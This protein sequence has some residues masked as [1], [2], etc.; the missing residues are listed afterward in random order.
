MR[1]KKIFWIYPGKLETSLD[2][3]TWL[4]TSKYLKEYGWNVEIASADLNKGWISEQKIKI[5]SFSR[6]NLY[7]FSN[8]LFHFL[9]AIRI[10]LSLNKIDVILFNQDSVPIMGLLYL[11][12][13]K[14]K[15][16]PYFILDNRSLPMA[17]T[18]AK[19]KIRTRFITWANIAAKK[20]FDGQTAITNRMAEA[21]KI[22]KETLLA[23]WPSG[24]N[25]EDFKYSSINRKARN[26]GSMLRLIYIGSIYRERN[27][28]EMCQAVDELATEGYPVSILL[29]GDGPDRQEL[30]SKYTFSHSISIL[31]SVPGQLVPYILANADVG[32]LPFPDEERFRVSS[33]IKLFE[34]LAAGMPILATKIACHTDVIRQN[35]VFWAENASVSSLSAAILNA[36]GNDGKFKEMQLLALE[37]SKNHTWEIAAKML[38]DGL[39]NSLFY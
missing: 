29:V 8:I 36:L 35:C 24:V 5:T 9:V 27:L 28:F 23:V 10:V 12:I 21:L 33:P 37:E 34:Y 31:P 20:L 14:L 18:T 19:E 7:L 16:R 30:Q 2:R 32:V 39:N 4:E 11:F 13:K 38:S 15:R 1:Y 17:E 25:Y 22:P 6:P 26:E 3:A